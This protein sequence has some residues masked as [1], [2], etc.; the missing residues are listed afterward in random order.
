MGFC[1]GLGVDALPRW[2]TNLAEVG[3]GLRNS[4][5]SLNQNCCCTNEDS[6]SGSR[7]LCSIISDPC[8]FGF[9]R[10]TVLVAAAANDFEELKRVLPQ[11][12]DKV[13]AATPRPSNVGSVWEPEKQMRDLLSEERLS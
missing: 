2:V 4:A 10:L 8:E 7:K 11:L 12:G 5:D 3:L 9:P 6:A 1:V 13:S